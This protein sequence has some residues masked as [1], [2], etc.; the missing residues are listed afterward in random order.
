[1]SR[2][3]ARHATPSTLSVEEKE[4]IYLCFY[5]GLQATCTRRGINATLSMEEGDATWNR[6]YDALHLEKSCTMLPAD[7]LTAEEDKD[8]INRFIRDVKAYRNMLHAHNTWLTT[9][10]KKAPKEP[11]KPTR[12]SAR[13]AAKTAK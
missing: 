2:R 13:I 6:L 12:R 8:I 7:R 5:P 3:S 11:K 10:P 1:M 9:M 4:K